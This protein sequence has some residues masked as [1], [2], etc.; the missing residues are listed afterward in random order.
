MPPRRT[1]LFQMHVKCK[2]TECNCALGS[3]GTV[4]QL[5]SAIKLRVIRA[6]EMYALAFREQHRQRAPAGCCI[7]ERREMKRDI[8]FYRIAAKYT[9]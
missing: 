2:E 9:F 6:E 4:A 1:L 7:T 8:L 3:S 5:I